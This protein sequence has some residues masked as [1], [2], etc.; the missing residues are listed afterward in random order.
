MEAGLALK[1]TDTGSGVVCASL[2]T[3][4]GRGQ[5]RP[6]AWDQA[7]PRRDGVCGGDAHGVA[8]R[9]KEALLAQERG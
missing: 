2:H 6:Q 3:L 4:V 1:Q 8:L 7:G 9:R 5:L